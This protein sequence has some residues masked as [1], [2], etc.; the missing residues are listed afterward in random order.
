MLQVQKQNIEIKVEDEPPSITIQVI[1]KQ[2]VSE[3]FG[4]ENWE[5]FDKLVQKES[6]WNPQAQNPHSTA[7][8]LCQFLN[9]TWKNGKTSDP[10]RQ[11]DEC[12]EYIASRYQTPNEAWKFHQKMNWY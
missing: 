4:S 11:L 3:R 7:Y 6:G 5:S 2:K 8:G 9:S 12:V 1:A 10:I